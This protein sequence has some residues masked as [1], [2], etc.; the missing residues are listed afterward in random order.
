MIKRR[1]KKKNSEL[2]RKMKTGFWELWTFKK[3]LKFV[4]TV[5]INYSHCSKA[6]PHGSHSKKKQL[7]KQKHHKVSFQNSFCCRPEA[8]FAERKKSSVTV[9]KSVQEQKLNRTPERRLDPLQKLKLQVP[10]GDTPTNS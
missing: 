6:P 7:K 8:P 5:F 3:T 2:S 9:N 4:F 10:P 1:K